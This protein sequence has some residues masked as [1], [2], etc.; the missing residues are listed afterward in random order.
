M[1][2]ALRQRYWIPG[3]SVAIRRILA[4]CVVCRRFHGIAGHQQMAD[5]PQD[6][7]SPDKPPFTCVGVDCFG[8]FEIKRGR[9]IIKR[10]GVI[11]T[12]LAIRAVHIETITSLDTDSFIHALRRFIA[13]R[14]QV[15]EIRSDNGTNFVGAERELQEA[16]QNWNHKQINDV[17]LQKKIKWIFNPPTGSHHGGIWERLIR[18]IKKILNSILRGQSLDEEGLHKMEGKNTQLSVGRCCTCGG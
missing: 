9:T 18:S 4:K 7:V 5:L 1:L 13:R 2:A 12:C 15:A 11:F 8:P 10:Y 14:G 16:I 6:R 3:A 17:L